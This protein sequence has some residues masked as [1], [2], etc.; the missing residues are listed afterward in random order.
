MKR[1]KFDCVEMMH[2]GGERIYEETK[3]MT[4]EEEIVYW[5]EQNREFREHVEVLRNKRRT[6]GSGTDG[7]AATSAGE[8]NRQP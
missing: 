8:P 3:D 2:Q 1:K 5:Q 7:G 6:D 4:P